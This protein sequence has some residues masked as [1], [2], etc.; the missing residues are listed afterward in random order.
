MLK[1]FDIK[2]HINFIGQSKIAFVT[3]IVLL[4]VTVGSLV[5]N[6]LNYGIDFMGGVLVEVKAEEVIDMAT[7]R[8]KIDALNLN[9]VSLQSSG[10]DGSEMII[11][12]AAN[13]DEKAQA[14]V[15]DTIK[16]ALGPSF[17]YRRIEV[18]GPKVGDELFN[19]SL[20][21]SIAALI[22]ISIYIWM[23]FEWQFAVVCLLSLAFDLLITVGFFS[24][25]QMDFSITVI[26]GLLSLAGYTTNDKI[27]NF[28][29]V[30]ENLKLFR[31]MPIPEL[32]NKSLNE[33]LS[34]TLLTSITTMLVLVVLMFLG[35][36]TLF[37]FA[38]CLFVGI[39]VGTLSSIYLAVP[40][41]RFCDI[42]NVGAPPEDVNPFTAVPKN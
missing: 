9:E 15:V 40:L 12:V 2:K 10:L 24:L 35:G 41:L 31:K 11:T 17:E 3:A 6:G 18:V 26:A 25:F 38:V 1:I 4:A 23:R 13:P 29:R 39:I 21:A 27:V 20:W 7:M 37:G 34:R 5:K 14:A 32:L 33:T 30:R 42:R 22:A 36:V 28:D 16:T 8:G 19:K